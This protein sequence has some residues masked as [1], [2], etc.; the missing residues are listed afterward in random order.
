MIN[1]R[2]Y[3][4]SY[5]GIGA[6]ISLSVY[7]KISLHSVGILTCFDALPFAKKYIGIVLNLL[8]G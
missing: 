1:S 8:S 5:R 4:L 6:L 7:D 2:M 3:P